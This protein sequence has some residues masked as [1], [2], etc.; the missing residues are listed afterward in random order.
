MVL[1]LT[2]IF[3]NYLISFFLGGGG[4]SC[5]Y[6]ETDEHYSYLRVEFHFWDL[7]L[8]FYV[9]LYPCHQGR[10]TLL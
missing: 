5:T 8:S 3:G 10:D 4:F 7:S 6:I 2:H 1:L 9:G